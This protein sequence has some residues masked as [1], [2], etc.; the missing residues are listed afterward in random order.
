MKIK[1]ERKESQAKKLI[2]VT[3]RA[4]IHASLAGEKSSIQYQP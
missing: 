1:S 3:H 2:I 4:T